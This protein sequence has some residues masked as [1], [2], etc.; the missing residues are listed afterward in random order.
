MKK[1]LILV[2]LGLFLGQPA[3]AEDEGVATKVG[4]GIRKGGE[5]AGHGIKKGIEATEKGLQK[6]ATV[7]A[8]GLE[9]AGRWIDRKV[10]GDK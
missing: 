6:G 5:A 4:N 8:K 1:A 7:T 2:L 9:K 10:H 3:F